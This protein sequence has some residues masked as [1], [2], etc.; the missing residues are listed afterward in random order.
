M[1]NHQSLVQGYLQMRGLLIV[2]RTAMC[3]LVIR[4]TSNEKPNLLLMEFTLRKLAIR[5]QVHG[6]RRIRGLGVAFYTIPAL[7][8]LLIRSKQFP[9]P[10]SSIVSLLVALTLLLE[11]AVPL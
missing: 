7:A 4:W 5:I 8:C 1:T 2:D 9:A 3:W 11:A 6:E 10:T